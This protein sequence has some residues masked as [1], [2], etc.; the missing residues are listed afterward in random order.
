MLFGPLRTVFVCLVVAFTL[1]GPHI[2]YAQAVLSVDGD[3][4]VDEQAGLGLDG[5]H[6]AKRGSLQGLPDGS[7]V[8]YRY[9]TSS[10]DDVVLMA[11]KRCVVVY[12]PGEVCANLG[13]DVSSDAQMG[14]LL[15]LFEC[16]DEAHSNRL[17]TLASLDV[18]VTYTSASRVSIGNLA[19][20]FGLQVEGRSYAAVEDA[21]GD[22]SKT[23]LFCDYAT[24]KS[25]SAMSVS[26]SRPWTESLAL[27]FESIDWSPLFVSARTVLAATA[28]SLVFGVLVAWFTLRRSNRT[29]SVCDCIFTLPMILPPS[30]CGL[31]LLY[32]TGKNS[33]SGRWLIDMGVNLPFTW[34]AAVIAAFVVSFPFMYRAARGAFED[35]DANLFD[36]ARTLGWPEWRILLRL[37]MPLS[38]PSLAAGAV[39][40]FARALGEFGATVFF[41]GNYAGVTQTIPLAIYYDWMAGDVASAWL[42]TAVVLVFSF[43]AILLLNTVG[44]RQG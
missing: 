7:S 2:A 44:K 24:L 1:M 33:A 21:R 5:F 42:W 17:A 12:V 19:F 8:G 36:A 28:L 20:Q 18:P 37:I 22:A 35:V 16:A 32:I 27:F 40:A 23:A 3:A 29:K 26:E 9:I 38:L 11:T 34:P 39:L 30:I 10:R 6:K 13:I 43:V 41:A 15:D 31:I 25:S 14:A 4:V